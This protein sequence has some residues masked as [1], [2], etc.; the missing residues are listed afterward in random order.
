MAAL[1]NLVFTGDEIAWVRTTC[2]YLPKAYLQ[3]LSTF[4]LYP[5]KQ[6]RCAWD[7]DTYDLSI[8]VSGLWIETILYEIPLLAL[9][10]EAYFRFVDTDWDYV[11]Q[12]GICSA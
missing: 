10:S 4:R 3:Y 5:R 12:Y 2:T 1:E 8:I 11:G 6:V 9:V 7:E